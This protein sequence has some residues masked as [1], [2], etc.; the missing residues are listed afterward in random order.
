MIL[1]IDLGTTN[2]AIAF[3]DE[4]SGP[5]LIPNAFNSPLTPSVVGFDLSDELLVGQAAKELQILHP[6][7]CA[8][9]FK[10]LMGTEETVK[11]LSKEYKPETLSAM[12]LSSLKSDAEAFLGHA[13]SE[14]VI[15]V[16][17]YFNNEQRQAT[18]RAGEIAGLKVRRIINEPT[19]AAI[20]YGFHD[21]KDEKI[22]AVFDLGGGTF[23]VSIVDFFDGIVEIQASSG[24]AFLGGEDFTVAIAKDILK[25]NNLSFEAVEFK[26]PK[27]LSRLISQ[28]ERAKIKLSDEDSYTFTMPDLNG[29]NSED[30]VTLTKEQIQA[31][32]E[33]I[34]KKLKKPIVTSLGDAELSYSD[35]DEV[36]LVGGACF[37][38]LIK[39]YV[40]KIFKQTPHNRLNPNY[41]V[42]QG[43]A[44]QAALIQDSKAVEDMVVTDVTPFSLGINISKQIGNEIRT[45]YFMPIINRN[46][47]IPVSRVERICT[48][49]PNQ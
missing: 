19:A 41:V 39:D 43:A 47:G 40:E 9:V 27:M 46:T 45:G 29:N 34:L 1:G 6:E 12:I 22:I 8:S 33:P 15:T 35:V 26:H 14:V 49:Y 48:L 21:S 44:V 36:I 16:P 42:A 20:A 23:D 28:C 37:M 38:P 18:L 4:D 2:S 17:A 10:R 25:A 13:I 30:E 31:S 7:R 5:F 3:I 11:I 24:E 32:T